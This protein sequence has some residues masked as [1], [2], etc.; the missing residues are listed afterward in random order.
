MLCL[1]VTC[2]TPTPKIQKE[3]KNFNLF[4]MFLSLS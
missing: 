3:Q 4:Y 1:F 2:P